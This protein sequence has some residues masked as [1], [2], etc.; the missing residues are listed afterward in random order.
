MA[1]TEPKFKKNAKTTNGRATGQR[2]RSPTPPSI[3]P[4]A[5]DRP[6]GVR[7]LASSASA[8]S[9]RCAASTP[10][11]FFHPIP[12]GLYLSGFYHLSTE[13]PMATSPEAD[14]GLGV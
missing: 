10:S 11:S 14:A 8:A 3:W 4:S 13:R 7:R 12:D 5:G 6:A 1:K 2:R 9:W